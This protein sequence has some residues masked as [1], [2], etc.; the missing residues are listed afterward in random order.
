MSG[1]ENRSIS[2]SELAYILSRPP[3]RVQVGFCSKLMRVIDCHGYNGKRCL[4][5]EY[6]EDDDDGDD[7]DDDNDDHDDDDDDDGVD[8]NDD[9]DDD[10][11]DD[12]DAVTQRGGCP[13]PLGCENKGVESMRCWCSGNTL[14]SH[15]KYSKLKLLHDQEY[16]LLISSNKTEIRVPFSLS[17]GWILQNRSAG[18]DKDCS[19][20]TYRTMTI[21]NVMDT[22][23]GI[24]RDNRIE[25]FFIRYLEQKLPGDLN[26]FRGLDTSTSVLTVALWL[27]CAPGTGDGLLESSSKEWVQMGSLV[28]K[29]HVSQLRPTECQI[30]KAEE[31]LIDLNRLLENFDLPRPV[32]IATASD[33]PPK[34]DPLLQPRRRTGR[35]R[36]L[37]KPLQLDTRRQS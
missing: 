4:T 17:C 28:W 3:T 19:N 10:D 7:D 35:A 6:E 26:F 29:R 12:D 27:D 23:T 37:V 34:T 31:Q 2:S 30:L 24:K 22:D 13:K 5:E 36:K 21:K 25:R 20:E 16:V 9:D 14:S 18:Q 8:D 1:I 11:N 15:F 32:P 33:V